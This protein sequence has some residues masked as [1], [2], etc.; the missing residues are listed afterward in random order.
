M[1]G[2]GFVSWLAL[3][4]TVVLLSGQQTLLAST[5]YSMTDFE[6]F[7]INIIEN[8]TTPKVV[9]NTTNDHQLFFKA[10]N[11]YS[12]LDDDGTKETTYTHSIDYYGYF[13]SYKCYKYDTGS[14]AVTGDELFV[15]KLVTDDKYCP[16]GQD[17]WSG[18]FLNWASM[19]RI[20]VIRK[21]FFG[22]HRRVDL[23]TKTVLE[24]SFLPH[25]AHSW[26]K[27]YAGDDLPKLTPFSP[28]TFTS[29]GNNYKC[30]L[31]NT[32]AAACQDGGSL[33]R[34]RIGI[35]IGN[36]TD[37][38]R[39]DYKSNEYSQVYSEPPLIKV[40]VGNYSLW[41]SNERWQLTW[42]ANSPVENQS[43]SNGNDPAN[44]GIYA[45]SSSPNY[46]QRLGEGNYIA[47]VQVCVDDTDVNGKSLLG[48][49]NCKRYPG[50]DGTSGTADD[51]Y[52]PIGLLQKYGDN[53]EMEFAMVAGSYLKHASGGVII[54]TM[55]DM[56]EEINTETDGTFP[57]VAEFAGGPKENNKAEGLINAWSLYRIIGYDG[58][59]G[60]GLYNSADSCPWG[61]S[62]ESD[63]T[64]SGV[65]RNW[66]NPLS[67]IYYQ[68]VNY[69]SYGGVIG[70]YRSNSSTGIPGLPV[71]Q[72]LADDPIDDDEYCASLNII[73]L[74]T[75]ASSYDADELDTA[76]YGPSTIWDDDD[77]PGDKT[78]SAMTDYVGGGEGLHSN[79]YF[80]GVTD[81]TSVTAADYQLCTS[82]EMNSLGQAYGLC[83][84]A[85]RLSGSYRI[86]GIAYY[87]HT[88][89]I[90]PD[91][92]NS[93]DIQG[94]QTIDTYSVSLATSLPVLEIPHP[95]DATKTVATIIPACRNASF[96]PQGNCAIV[97]YKIVSEGPTSGDIFIVWE[98]S[99]QGGDFDQDMW[100]TLHY[101]LNSASEPTQI[102][103]TTDVIAK[104]TPY[105]MGFGYIIS[106]TTNDGFH[107]HSG[108]DGF[109]Y[110]EDADT[111]DDCNDANG[112][113]AADSASSITYTL[114]S[115]TAK[116][117][118]DPLWYA[119]KWGGFV[120]SN[121][122]DL[123]DLVSEWDS[124]NN[125]TWDDGSDGIPDNYF[126]AADPEKLE[127]AMDRV[128]S[129][130]LE[131]TSSG[132]AAAV[133]S[134]NVRGEGALYQAY[135]EPLRKDTDGKEVRWIGEV[136]ALWLD[137]YG[138]SRQDCSPPS[139]SV[140]NPATDDTC[141][142]VDLD[143]GAPNG[144]LD[145]Y[146]I[147]NVVSTY[148]DEGDGKTKVKIYKSPKPD[149]F[150]PVSMQ[151]VV[152]LYNDT[153]TNGDLDLVPNSMEGVVGTY[154]SGTQQLTIDPYSITGLVTAYDETTG[155]VTLEVASGDWTGETGVAYTGWRATISTGGGI[156]FS[157]DTISMAAHA[158]LVVALS[159]IDPAITSGIGTATITLS[160]RNI[161]GRSG[162]IFDDWDVE[163]LAGSSAEGE[164][165]GVGLK[166]TNQ[167][168]GPFLL[169]SGSDDFSSCTR[170]KIATYNVI[171]A[172][173]D[174]TSD[175]YAD[176]LVSNLDT[177]VGTG[178][179]DTSLTLTNSGDL[180]LT[181]SPTYDWLATGQRVLIA[182]YSYKTADLNDINYI[183][184]ARENLAGI[185]ES[186]LTV[187]RLYDLSAAYGRYI[188]TWIDD[189]LDGI[190]D[191]GEY[192][193]FQANLIDS[194]NYRFFDVASE[195]DAEEVVDYIRG[196]EQTGSR[197]RT[198]KNDGITDTVQR[199]GD[200]VNSTPT[201]VSAPQEAFDLLYKDTSYKTFFKQYQK[202]RVVIYVGGN[203]GLLHAINGGFYTRTT[204][205]GGNT[206]VQYSV[207]GFEHDG[208][209][210]AT[211]HPL[212][213][214][215]W[216]YAPYNLLSHL[217]WL[218][219]NDYAD[220]H[221]YYLDAKP[222]V[223]DANIFPDNVDHP[224]G[225]GTV[226][227]IGMNIGGGL[228]EV[229]VDSDGDGSTDTTADLKSAYIVFDITNPEVEPVLLGEIPMP[230][231]SF[232]TVYP[233]V[234]AFRDVNGTSC[235]GGLTAC[236]SWYLMFGTGPDN[237]YDGIQDHESTQT[238]KA[239]LFDLSQLTTATGPQPASGTAV[240]GSDCSV[241]P[242]GS[243]TY[244]L[245]ECTTNVSPSFSGDPVVVDWDLDFFADTSYFGLVGDYSA[246]S[247]RLMRWAF[248]NDATPGNWDDPDT[249][250]DSGK[251]VL[252]QPVPAYDDR[253]KKWVYFGTGR[254]FSSGDKT[255]T[256]QQTLFGVKEDDSGS[257]VLSASLVDV[258]D[259]EVYSDGDLD[260]TLPVGVSNFDDLEEYIA[261]ASG[262]KG[263]M[264]N[265]PM[266]SG[267]LGTDA[268]TRNTSRSA[269]AGGVLFTS[270]FQPSEDPCEGEGLSRLYGLYYKTGTAYPDSVFGYTITTKDGKVVYL[271]NKY[272]DLGR[273]IATAPSLHTGAG[274]G[275][276]S[277]R[278]FT[279]LSTGDIVQAEAD[280]VL[281]VRTG[282]TAW[283]DR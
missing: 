133:V 98:D 194:V 138:Y 126:Y 185:T 223:F 112:C 91:S 36:T 149:K 147:D 43:A 51:N 166:M 27:Y 190:V 238:A 150:A 216:A 123:P 240:A 26:A 87:A 187:N 116:L 100:G 282:K 243:S 58:S 262:V 157:T 172:T 48:R 275:A 159:P 55:G 179:S 23:S 148:Y 253:F 241:V 236:N 70:D 82:K 118:E 219:E 113:Y 29:G 94:S 206:T 283:T 202:R 25:D 191:S 162:D 103:I 203:D 192:R 215:I 62:K 64:K 16:T 120:D 196:I 226:L 86:A 276:D 15:P 66:G 151:G 200:I 65:C 141:P 143:C 193:P 18:N 168:S 34:K 270:V 198:I 210:T 218:Q 222:R 264:M 140:Y 224:G 20:D 245:I 229:D 205:S 53:E 225:W 30:D 31:G 251:P 127:E 59:S 277:V 186:L 199:L 214:E 232:T 156:Y 152:E 33:D 163:C 3:F 96:S 24:R 242:L 80:L 135:Y 4:G 49:E 204:D 124:K 68:S 256:W 42:S 1:H 273:G 254:Y 41:A 11:D 144:I 197:N 61:L 165:Q 5:D 75:S 142:N 272:I 74:N 244:N 235:T 104:S 189:D 271:S 201:V 56:L 60:N 102:T 250:I 110:S 79:N 131:R 40:V 269:L 188:N 95:S 252:A 45:Y 37:I 233:A 217:Q 268:S 73:N 274:A 105:L 8:S 39:G 173:G 153:G 182:N 212:G 213:A 136:Q 22:G 207:N 267:T 257:T 181:V 19:S 246:S 259:I 106:G 211:P 146:C 209:T 174:A 167:S 89:D 78:T 137:S 90:R 92:D 266:L 220:S 154:D 230:D 278:A 129:A 71:P 57:L 28:G 227:V 169:T 175:T 184:N 76:S 9:I 122:N 158:A 108:I 54:R 164:A 183:W 130:I 93:R 261:N 125:S 132:T 114:G 2:I 85:P 128:F 6:S 177:L 176:W 249:F 195:T 119:A 237:S 67:E 139:T 10:Y 7:P 111:G 99:E 145:D 263:W 255:S 17:Y 13:D 234:A 258:S 69:L 46:T 178:T 38:N 52:K 50:P 279:Q 239:Y 107:V 161:I 115:T 72:S 281:S 208:T 32:A 221:V 170:V 117:L 247:G 83:P 97:D 88:K 35:T 44:S 77:L 84:E 180:S 109:K 231:D 63:V 228:M 134:N 171:G 265:L 155:E 21:M 81:T 248:N 160:T 260:G 121:G 14:A 47:R 101:D 280:P 12:D